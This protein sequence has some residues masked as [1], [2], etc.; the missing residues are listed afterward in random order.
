[1]IVFTRTVS[2]AP[3]KNGSAMAFAHEVTAYLKNNMGMELEVLVPIGG[4]PNRITW[5]SRYADLAAYDKTTSAMMADPQYLKLVL[6]GS[7][8]FL[9]GSVFDSL[10]S[11]V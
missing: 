11:K 2:V 1:M 10:W 4:N 7:E 5:T 9:A 3:G 6:S 8:N